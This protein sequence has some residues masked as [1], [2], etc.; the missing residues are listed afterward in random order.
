MSSLGQKLAAVL[1]SAVLAFLILMAGQT[2]WSVLL[3]LNF[4]N[5]TSALPWSV[6]VMAV[7]L[8]LM[9]Q[10]L[11][12][13]GRPRSTSE[14][15]RRLLRANPVPPKTFALSFLCGVLAVIALAGYWI[16]LFQFVKTPPNILADASRYP[17]LTV[18]LVTA[19]SSLVSPISE[20]IAFRGYAQQIL[21]GRFSG[22]V[23]VTLSSMLFMLAHANHGLYWPKL[24]V[25]FLVGVVF[26]TIALL[27]NSILTTLP[28]HIV[29]DVTFFVLIWPR[30]AARVLVTEGGADQWFWAHAIQAF[31]FT[32]LA[33]A[34]FWYLNKKGERAP[35]LE[36]ARL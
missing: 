18:I 12:G 19:M 5:R 32:L 27:T 35:A 14:K 15:R 10:Y 33:L 4:R 22:R 13:K 28:V 17:F 2:P 23:A 7:V 25:Y 31:V 9:W 30:D 8:W 20:E 24:T 26:G 34:G 29:G 16:V 1:V 36:R 3:A 21:E 6:A 11:G